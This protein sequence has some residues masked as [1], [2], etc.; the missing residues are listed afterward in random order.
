MDDLRYCSCIWM[1]REKRQRMTQRSIILSIVKSMGTLQLY[2]KPE[3]ITRPFQKA[4]CPVYLDFHRLCFPLLCYRSWLKYRDMG[5]T[6]NS[7]GKWGT[8][9]GDL[10]TAYRAFS[11]KH[12]VTKLL[13]LSV[14]VHNAILHYSYAQ[15]SSVLGSVLHKIIHC[16]VLKFVSCHRHNRGLTGGRRFQCHKRCQDLKQGFESNLKGF[17]ESKR[18]SRK[19][20]IFNVNIYLLYFWNCIVIFLLSIFLK[21]PN[22]Q[23]KDVP[24]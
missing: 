10:G 9:K 8:G 3:E 13:F 24:L 20:A 11:L 12:T 16:F 17:M 21:V 7:I 5:K 2:S 4:V 22:M 18:T 15:N 19:I 1:K 23:R 6:I 14:A